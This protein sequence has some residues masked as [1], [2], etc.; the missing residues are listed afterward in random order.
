MSE[1]TEIVMLLKELVNRVRELEKVAYH[2]DNLLMK[3]GF[4]V[5]DSPTP[6][7]QNSV[8][9][10]GMDDITKMSFDDMAD[11]ISKME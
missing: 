3:S 6:K 2:N 7:M 11:M 4:V 9:T 10:V 8:G 1:N 5:V